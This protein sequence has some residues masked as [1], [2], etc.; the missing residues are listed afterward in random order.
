MTATN[1][2][3][4]I[5]AYTNA[6]GEFALYGVPEGTYQIKVE[7]DPISGLDPITKDN[8]E[9]DDDGTTDVETLFLE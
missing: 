3:N 2:S 7:P 8:V 1:A 4:R 5:S 6:S 9:V